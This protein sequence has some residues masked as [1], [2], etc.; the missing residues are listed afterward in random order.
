MVSFQCARCGDVIKKPKVAGHAQTCG[1]NGFSCVDCMENFDNESVKKH[2]ACMTEAHRYQGQW[3]QATN[4]TAAKKTTAAVDSEEEEERAKGIVKPPAQAPQKRRRPMPANFSDSSDD[5][6]EAPKRAPPA[7][8]AFLESK[9]T[10]SPKHVPSAVV[11]TASSARAIVETFEVDSDIG[12]FLEVIANIC[13]ADGGE[14]SSIS[15]KAA[16]EEL[17]IRYKKRIAKQLELTIAKAVQESI[18]HGNNTCPVVIDK[19][20]GLLRKK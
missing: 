12:R 11:A 7:P 1:T 20:S 18:S 15:L 8:K 9:A 13:E 5:D 17:A 3:R 6:N 16:A 2:S 4:G 10:K 14:S 19:S